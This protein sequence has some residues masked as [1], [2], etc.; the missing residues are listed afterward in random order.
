MC[1][2]ASG[3]CRLCDVR[4]ATS[5]VRTVVTVIIRPVK[6]MMAPVSTEGM[7]R[8][9]L[10]WP[11]SICCAVGLLLV[12]VVLLVLAG[13]RRT[14]GAMLV[15]LVAFLLSVIAFATQVGMMPVAA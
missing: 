3:W 14:G 9:G 4:V 5:R 2:G 10:S 6:T 11:G 7:V 1:G 12:A 8:M 13:S 15:R